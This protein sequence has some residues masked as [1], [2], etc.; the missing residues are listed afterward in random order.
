[1]VAGCGAKVVERNTRRASCVSPV[2]TPSLLT[3]CNFD[4]RFAEASRR[5]LREVLDARPR[6]IAAHASAGHP[7]ALQGVLSDPSLA[8]RLSTTRAAREVAALESFFATL[9]ADT[10]AQ[11]V[12]GGSRA[13]GQGDRAVYGYRHVRVAADAA[14]V[15]TLLLSDA[16]LRS[17]VPVV[18][19]AYVALVEDVRAA[20]GTVH[21]VS[22]GHASGEAL[23]ALSGVAA[24]LR[25]S[26]GDMD[27]AVAALSAAL[28]STASALPL[29]DAVVAG[30]AH[31][32]VLHSAAAAGAG[33]AARGRG[34]GRPRA[35][36]RRRNGAV[37]WD[38]GDDDSEG[39]SDSDASYKQPGGPPRPRA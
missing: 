14:A 3:H 6:F 38:A 17:R 10:V 7:R 5:G 8:P 21:V 32:G 28:E 37:A 30:E 23:T 1:M 31:G 20:G 4:C 39:S 15:G 2:E 13:G 36:G 24:V 26:V 18:R 19:A 11:G 22:S 33:D 35:T 34:A 16:L 25:Y 29:R 12:D 27:A 9:H